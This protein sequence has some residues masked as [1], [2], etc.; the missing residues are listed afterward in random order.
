MPYQTSEGSNLNRYM[1][2]W[3]SGQIGKASDFP[4]ES[5]LRKIQVFQEVYLP[6]RPTVV[7]ASCKMIWTDEMNLCFMMP[8][9]PWEEVS[10]QG[11]TE[12]HAIMQQ[13]VTMFSVQCVSLDLIKVLFEL[14][15]IDSCSLS[16]RWGDNN[17][18]TLETENLNL[19]EAGRS[20]RSSLNG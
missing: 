5:V 1:L 17:S 12:K 13:S 3:W 14:Q 9:S 6:V 10:D 8:V 19:R 20:S 16:K 4:K 18:S 11:L 2:Q 7:R 15:L